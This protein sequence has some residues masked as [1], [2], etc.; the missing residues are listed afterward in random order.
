MAHIWQLFLLS[1]LHMLMT[2]CIARVPSLR[3]R[4]CWE[5]QAP[6]PAAPVSSW[7]A[8]FCLRWGAGPAPVSQLVGRR[9]LL[10]SSAPAVLDRR[11]PN[12]W[13]VVPTAET[14]GRGS[15][16][17]FTI[18]VNGVNNQFLKYCHFLFSRMHQRI[19]L[20]WKLKAFVDLGEF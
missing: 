18:F 15:G 7:H 1:Q 3:D 16:T 6:S 14:Q 10:C 4:S 20:I 19:M 12:S 5:A 2:S 13:D 8:F 9:F 11:S 17:T